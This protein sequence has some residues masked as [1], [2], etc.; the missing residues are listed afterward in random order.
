VE[1]SAMRLDEV[2]G[3]VMRA[4]EEQFQDLG[5]AERRT[6]LQGLAQL[7]QLG[8]AARELIAER[9]YGVL[10]RRLDRAERRLPK[11]W[12]RGRLFH[13]PPLRLDALPPFGLQPV[14]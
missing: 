1:I 3:V 2:R 7:G 13:L 10:G 5:I 9:R 14:L 11:V 4:T 8:I 6:G 12:I